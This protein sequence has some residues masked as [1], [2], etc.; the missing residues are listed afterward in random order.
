M[1]WVV[2]LAGAAALGFVVLAAALRRH[3]LALVG[4]GLGVAAVTAGLLAGWPPVPV[5]IGGALG[6]VGASEVSRWLVDARRRGGRVAIEGAVVAQSARGA[7]AA[8]VV[9]LVAALLVSARPSGSV[10]GLWVAAAVVGIAL[11]VGAGA[12]ALSGL[13]TST[14]VASRP[15]RT[16]LLAGLIVAA[17]PTLAALGAAGRLPGAD[18]STPTVVGQD[19]AEARP[20]TPEETITS[21]EEEALAAEQPA[22]STGVFVATLVVVIALLLILGRR[23]Q[24]IP[25]EDL[26]PDR[27]APAELPPLGEAAEGLD[28]ISQRAVIASVDEALVQLRSD[29]EPRLAVRMAYATVAAGL[30]GPTFRRDRAESEEEYL[31]R[32]L[33]QFGAGAA[34][35]RRL[36]EL[37]EIARFSDDP[38]TAVMRDAALT[39][40]DEVRGQLANRSVGAT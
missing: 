23:T 39:S 38:V 26:V 33:G 34:S 25:P 15:A 14:L 30:G 32:V 18:R 40:L 9:A 24:I 12:R 31:R 5:A 13:G 21:P 17:V 29:V 19:A 37:F 1:N 3:S 35:L 4:L 2:G 36:T 10:P 22:D 16:L 6:A 7:G 20:N 11:V 27:L 28:R 8:A